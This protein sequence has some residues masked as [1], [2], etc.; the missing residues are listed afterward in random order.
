MLFVPHGSGDDQENT[1]NQVGVLPVVHT[2][3][4]MV[5]SVASA[6]SPG[7]PDLSYMNNQNNAVGVSAI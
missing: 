5:L 6:A 7:Q 4:S 3:K 1:K 2:D